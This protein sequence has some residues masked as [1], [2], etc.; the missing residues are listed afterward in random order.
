MFTCTQLPPD[1]RDTS[2]IIGPMRLIIACALSILLA[3]A[4][5][6]ETSQPL[7]ALRDGKTTV[8]GQPYIKSVAEL[9]ADI[10]GGDS[11]ARG[12]ARGILSRLTDQEAAE[13]LAMLPPAFDAESKSVNWEIVSTY[14]ALGEAT[15]DRHY[16]DLLGAIESGTPK[17]AHIAMQKIRPSPE[18]REEVV[19]ALL[20]VFDDPATHKSI[21]SQTASQLIK[22]GASERLANHISPM[23]DDP[24][25]KVR[26]HAVAL[27]S[28]SKMQSEFAVPLLE[29]ALDNSMEMVVDHAIGAL[30]SKHRPASAHEIAAK[31]TIALIMT[32]DNFTRSRLFTK[33]RLKRAQASSA[34]PLLLTY[35]ESPKTNERIYA[36]Q[37]L[38]EMGE[39]ARA[40]LDPLEVVA[41]EADPVTRR[42]AVKAIEC[43]S[44]P[45]CRDLSA[46]RKEAAYLP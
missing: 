10:L 1:L 46:Y 11:T 45:H 27:L 23:L 26:I 7:E 20:E 38:A 37:A 9:A 16:S 3:T 34:V 21:R 42:F 14:D 41:R 15:A 17:D 43:I 24:K 18:Q 33:L 25:R 2:L 39:V 30:F 13:L 6:A 35:L 32:S 40:A 5:Q 8:A 12:L 31:K 44:E 19:V 4:A 22:H 29:K 28:M 36:I